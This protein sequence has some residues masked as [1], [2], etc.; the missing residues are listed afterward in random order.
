MLH[1][2]FSEHF[3]LLKLI[4]MQL[5]SISSCLITSYLLQIIPPAVQGLWLENRSLLWYGFKKKNSLFFFPLSLKLSYSSVNGCTAVPEKAE[6]CVSEGKGAGNP[7]AKSSVQRECGRK[8][9]LFAKQE[10]PQEAMQEDAE[11]SCSWGSNIR[12]SPDTA[13]R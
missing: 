13:V 5:E 11:D 3:F 4:L 12:A 10:V 7:S 1:N 8:D 6:L 9:R 2:P